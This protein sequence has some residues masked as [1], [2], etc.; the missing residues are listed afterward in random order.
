MDDKILEDGIRSSIEPGLQ[1]LSKT[2]LNAHIKSMYALP[3]RLTFYSAV[4]AG[5]D[6]QVPRAT[7]ILTD[8]SGLV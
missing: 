4:M 5:G 8:N 7:D 2:Y 6:E 3:V 1:E